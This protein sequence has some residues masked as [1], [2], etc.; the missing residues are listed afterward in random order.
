MAWAQWDAVEHLV[1]M[2]PPGKDVHLL[3]AALDH[4]LEAD[5]DKAIGLPKGGSFKHYRRR[6]RG[7]S[8]LHVREYARHYEVHWDR[9]DPRLRP[10]GHWWHDVRGGKSTL[11]AGCALL[12]ALA[13]LPFL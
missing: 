8:C 3:K 6:V 10:L 5:M 7:V 13:A 11:M 4:P 12:G 2:Q 1:L 9:L